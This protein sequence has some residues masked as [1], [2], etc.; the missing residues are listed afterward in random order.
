M[1]YLKVHWKGR[2]HHHPQI[3][4]ISSHSYVGNRTIAQ[5]AAEQVVHRPFSPPL[6]KARR[7]Q[8]CKVFLR[9]CRSRN[10]R[11]SS[12]TIITVRKRTLRAKHNLQV[13]GWDSST[14]E[15]ANFQGHRHPSFAQISVP[16]R[17]RS[18]LPAHIVVRRTTTIPSVD[19]AA[20]SISRRSEDSLLEKENREV[21]V[22]FSNAPSYATTN[23]IPPRITTQSPTVSTLS[24]QPHSVYTGNPEGRHRT[25]DPRITP[26]NNLKGEQYLH[27]NFRPAG[28]RPSVTRPTGLRR[29]T[30]PQEI[31]AEGSRRPTTSIADQRPVSMSVD[32]SD[33]RG[34][35]QLSGNSASNLTYG[36]S[37]SRTPSERRA[38]RKF[39]KELER[40]LQ[41]T[42]DLPQRASLASLPSITTTISIHT[43]ADLEP[44]KSEFHAA[45]LAITSDEQRGMAFGWS[46]KNKRAV[47]PPPVANRPERSRY[48]YENEKSSKK[49]D[50]FPSYASG[51]TGTTVM[52][53]TLPHEKT[54][55]A[56]KTPIQRRH[57]SSDHTIVGFTPPHEMVDRVA[58]STPRQTTKKS[59]PWLRKQESSPPD[60]ALGKKNTVHEDDVIKD[61]RVAGEGPRISSF[62]SSPKPGVERRVRQSP[63]RF[64]CTCFN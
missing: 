57:S 20:C 34:L 47:T 25:Y 15:V 27:P 24:T 21:T 30:R 43:I 10:S 62:S 7:R 16:V 18:A 58:N 29:P 46:S 33:H 53:F 11:R 17:P 4:V 32:A 19:G 52:G 54:Y 23:H 36:I 56:P 9:T 12:S 13:Y 5:V 38:L 31:S 50:R 63:G 60:F 51:S 26:A 14:A 41:A 8:V 49:P 28:S 61:M 1:T 44:Y 35:S 22:N 37:I 45:G 3:R 40:H 42:R 55:D 6:I 2:P 48:G 39:T 59:L 64:Y